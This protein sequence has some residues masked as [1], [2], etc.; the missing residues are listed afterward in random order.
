MPLTFAGESL[1]AAAIAV[2]E[3]AVKIA[4]TAVSA[5]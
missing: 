1:T 4:E 5:R 2:V 3:I